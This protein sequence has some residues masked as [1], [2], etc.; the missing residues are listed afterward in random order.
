[1]QFLIP[2]KKKKNRKKIYSV[3]IPKMKKDEQSSTSRTFLNLH[4][5]HS[6]F[7]GDLVREDGDL[8][9]FG[10]EK[11]GSHQRRTPWPRLVPP[12]H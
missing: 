1:M 4:L 6:D 12:P 9:G 3:I 2:S 7:A 8:V 10:V 5:S 11:I